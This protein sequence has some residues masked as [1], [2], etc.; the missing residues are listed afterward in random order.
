MTLADIIE[1][2]LGSASVGIL[3]KDRLK[4]IAGDMGNVF[5]KH[6]ATYPEIMA[7]VAYTLQVIDSNAT[8]TPVQ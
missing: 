8:K 1:Y 4:I 2:L 3:D 7:V 6:E 5:V